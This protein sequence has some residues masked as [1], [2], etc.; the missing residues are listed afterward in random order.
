MDGSIYRKFQTCQSKKLGFFR[1][2]VCDLVKEV[3][4]KINRGVGAKN[5][6]IEWIQDWSLDPWD[7]VV[8][9]V[10]RGEGSNI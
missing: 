9:E 10:E 4:A 2:Y 7:Q 8:Q 5:S 1:Q 3:G 6:L